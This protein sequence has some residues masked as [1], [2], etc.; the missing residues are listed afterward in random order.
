MRKSVWKLVVLLLCILV[1]PLLA[2]SPSP[3]SNT[4]RNLTLHTPIDYVCFPVDGN[5][6]AAL[7]PYTCPGYGTVVQTTTTWAQLT[8][9]VKK[10]II[11]PQQI[12]VVV[13]N[14]T[15]GNNLVNTPCSITQ[16]Q[17]S[18]AITFS[19]G[20]SAGDLLAVKLFNNLTGTADYNVEE[21][22][23]NLQ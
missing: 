5:G 11:G 14:F 23:W 4:G 17:K 15:T 1:V 8:A 12:S 22:S 19:A 2:Q 16:G 9:H 6:P 13:E 7:V 21:I 20:A 10:P 3:L 18:C